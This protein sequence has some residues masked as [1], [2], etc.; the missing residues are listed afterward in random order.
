MVDDKKLRTKDQTPADD[1]LVEENRFTPYGA[2]SE[3]HP[4]KPITGAPKDSAKKD[5]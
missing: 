1:V 3:A 2:I 4:G 5:K